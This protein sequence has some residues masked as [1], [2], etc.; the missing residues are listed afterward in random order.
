MLESDQN[1]FHRVFLRPVPEHREGVLLH[2]SVTLIHARDVNFRKE[3][4]SGRN[5]WVLRSAVDAEEIDAIVK[6]CVG[7]ADNSSVPVGECL[8]TPIFQTI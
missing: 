7:R 2:S 8:V 5:G 4:D 1:F 3:L 6:V